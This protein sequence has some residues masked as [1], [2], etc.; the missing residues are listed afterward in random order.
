M[1]FLSGEKFEEF[2]DSLIRRIKGLFDLKKRFLDQGREFLDSCF[3]QFESMRQAVDVRTQQL[4]QMEMIASHASLTQIKMQ[5]ELA[6]KQQD[7]DDLQKRHMEELDHKGSEA[8]A[9]IKEREKLMRVIEEE[10]EATAEDSRRNSELVHQWREKA[11]KLTKAR[12]LW[13]KRAVNAEEQL[14]HERLEAEER[15][16]ELLSNRQVDAGNHKIKQLKELIDARNH[17]TKQ[18]QDFLELTKK[19]VTEYESGFVC[20]PG[21]PSPSAQVLARINEKLREDLTDKKHKLSDNQKRI[22]S[23]TKELDAARQETRMV[24]KA[25]KM[26]EKTIYQAVSRLN[27]ASSKDL[28]ENSLLPMSAIDPGQADSSGDDSAAG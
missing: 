22:A 3:E 14:R 1:N 16:V 4:E 19:K 26:R 23:L 27:V 12:G 11:M 9:L 6:K 18:L 17:E 5:D 10:R 25:L 20:L 24:R 28:A 2:S 13:D 7:I 21:N 8:A 15:I